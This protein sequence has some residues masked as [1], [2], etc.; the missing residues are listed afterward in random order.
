[1]ERQT[2][3]KR[4]RVPKDP[5]SFKIWLEKVGFAD[6]DDLESF[7]NIANLISKIEK[8]NER[9]LQNLYQLA[10]V[11]YGKTT[12]FTSAE[13]TDYFHLSKRLKIL[14]NK[15]YLK[16]EDEQSMLEEFRT[17][18]ECDINKFIVSLNRTVRKSPKIVKKFIRNVTE[19]LVN[20]NRLELS[21]KLQLHSAIRK[22][23]KYFPLRDELD[24][25]YFLK[26]S[27]CVSCGKE[28]HEVT[29]YLY[30]YPDLPKILIPQ[31]QNCHDNSVK[32]DYKIMAEIFATYAH[33]VEE[34]FHKIH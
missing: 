30:P 3:Q 25:K 21:E 34:A 8:D 29:L 1:M 9:R 15:L 16:Y 4:R 19:I 6:V 31:C 28:G 20:F 11:I 18:Y 14:L 17:I 32:I 23:Y 2:K 12:P 22:L 33:N 7:L 24:D 27:R 26:Y 13:L 10:Q 5:E